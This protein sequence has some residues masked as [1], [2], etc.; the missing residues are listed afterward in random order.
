MC[1]I[2]AKASSFTKDIMRPPSP[3]VLRNIDP[4]MYEPWQMNERE[5]YLAIK[6]IK[7]IQGRIPTKVYFVSLNIF[8]ILYGKKKLFLGKSFTVLY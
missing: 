5:R 1:N 7:L 2:I 4:S 6:C 8:H 3:V